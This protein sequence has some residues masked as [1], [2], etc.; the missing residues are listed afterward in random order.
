MNK[1]EQFDNSMKKIIN[2]EN[3]LSELKNLENIPLSKV[4]ELRQEASVHY[5]KCNEILKDLKDNSKQ[6]NE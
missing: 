2:I 3:E 1:Y 5:T 4:M 6:S